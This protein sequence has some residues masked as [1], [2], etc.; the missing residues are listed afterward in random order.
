M[1]DFQKIAMRIAERKMAGHEYYDPRK[2]RLS[3]E[4]V[5][6]L[7]VHEHDQAYDAHIHGWYSV[8]DLWHFR[9]Y[10][11]T[12]STARA[13]VALVDGEYVDMPGPEKWDA[14][15]ADMQEN[16]W[17]KD[18]QPVILEI[19]KNGRVKVGEGNHRL[20]IAREIG[21]RKVPVRFWFKQRVDGG[22]QV[23][24]L[25]S[26]GGDNGDDGASVDDIL[27]QLGF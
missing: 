3:V 9:E 23:V 21:M 2:K 16:G 12:R 1:I 6:E 15:K 24:D 22:E 14:I 5:T 4:Q 26:D 7:W 20:A 27:D 18:Q 8:R 13:G 17:R 11:W 19:G 25:P 10:T